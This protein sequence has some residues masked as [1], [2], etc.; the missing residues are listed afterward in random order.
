MSLSLTTQIEESGGT[1]TSLALAKYLLL[2]GRAKPV[3]HLYTPVNN[4]LSRRSLCNR[5]FQ[6]GRSNDRVTTLTPFGVVLHAQG[7]TNTRVLLTH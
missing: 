3:P 4:Q 2:L 7:S 5:P 1:Q 6:A